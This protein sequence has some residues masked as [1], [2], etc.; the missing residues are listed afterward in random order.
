VK[1]W[2]EKEDMISRWMASGMLWAE[3]GY[4][5]VRGHEDLG[6]LVRALAQRGAARPT[7]PQADVS[8]TT[9][10][11]SEDETKSTLSTTMK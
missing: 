10:A 8:L 6:H 3:A 2:N 11:V 9:P 4:R 5:K 7:P 1:R